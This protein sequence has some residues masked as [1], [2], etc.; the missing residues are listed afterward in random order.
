MGYRIQEVESGIQGLGYGIQGVKSAIQGVDF[1]IQGMESG[2]RRP[3]GLAHMGR[4]S[5][6]KF[7]S[8]AV[9]T[10]DRLLKGKMS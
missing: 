3:P 10:P 2:V 6:I 4:I 9:V 8:V 7:F 1:G 5:S